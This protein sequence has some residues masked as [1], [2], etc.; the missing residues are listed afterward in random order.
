MTL[1]L[2]NQTTLLVSHELGLASKWVQV[3]SV[4]RNPQACECIASLT[5]FQHRP[6]HE[7]MKRFEGAQNRGNA[8]QIWSATE[9]GTCAHKRRAGA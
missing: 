2:K 3:R 9:T 8:D 7:K 6:H 5:V 1:L 4:T